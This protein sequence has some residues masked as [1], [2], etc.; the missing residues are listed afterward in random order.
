[1]KQWSGLLKKEWSAMNGQFYVTIVAALMFV[2]LI[3]FGSILLNWGLNALELSVT[4]SSIWLM[5]G[6]LIPT[7]ILLIS[8]GKE[9]NRPDI[10]LHSTS[11]IF[12]LFGS[13]VVFSGFIGFVNMLIPILVIIAESRFVYFLVDIP[14]KTMLGLGGFMLLVFYILSLL[15]LCTGLFFGVLYQLIKP[16]LKGFSGP[17]VLI[18]FLFSSWVLERITSTT[19]YEK[20]ANF[21]PLIGPDKEVFNFT[22]GKHFLEIDLISFRSGIILFDLLMAVLLFIAAVVLFE[23]K[24]RI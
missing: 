9:M 13:K 18:L 21:G 11:S 4:L 12:K 15:I 24:V 8:L 17:V 19:M 2:L 22:S 1:M 10:W 14:F 16:V 23:K 6:M 3:P 5:L 20:I 7:I